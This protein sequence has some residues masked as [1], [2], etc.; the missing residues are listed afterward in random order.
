M[1]GA[2]VAVE[3]KQNLAKNFSYKDVRMYINYIRIYINI[4]I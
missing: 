1:N 4:L 3:E 2:E